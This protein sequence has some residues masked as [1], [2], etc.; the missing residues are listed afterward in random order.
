MRASH[1]QVDFLKQDFDRCMI[2]IF[3]TEGRY[4]RELSSGRIEHIVGILEITHEQCKG[5]WGCR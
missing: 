4:H 2:V 5:F 3:V 1:S